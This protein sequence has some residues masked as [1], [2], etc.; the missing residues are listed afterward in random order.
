[1]ETTDFRLSLATDLLLNP[2][3]LRALLIPLLFVLNSCGRAGLSVPA[4]D[5]ALHLIGRWDRSTPSAPRA[6]WPGFGVECDFTGR[7]IAVRMDDPGNYYQVEIDGMPRGMICGRGKGRAV[8]LADNLPAGSH[9]LRL[10]RRNISFDRPTTLEG[11]VLGEGERMQELPVVARKKIEFIGDSYTVA[12]GNEATAA[13]LAWR[14]K[15]PVTHTGAG[16]AG[17]IARAFHADYHVVSRSGS[18]VLCD[19]LGN[20]A[21]PMLERYGWT[22]M[23]QATPDWDF[24]S[25]TPDLVVI[26]LGVNDYSGLKRPDGTVSEA[27]AS[28]FRRAYAGLLAKVRHHHPRVEIV[29]LAHFHPWVREQ[30][31]RVID[32]GVN[33]GDR[34]LHYAQFDE[35]PGGYVA[36][37]HPTVATHRKMAEQILPQI[38]GIGGFRTSPAGR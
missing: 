37:G 14:D 18:G 20:R 26:C 6:S 22:L 4:D 12:E 7:S 21:E 2:I 15:Y 11:F 35:F 31:K 8:T 24:S 13:S 29:A 36:D 38:E 34:C 19:Y 17:E 28:A 27:D 33:E 16:Y 10:T 9:H 30:V 1:L 25:W 3:V 32:D 5:P 23:E